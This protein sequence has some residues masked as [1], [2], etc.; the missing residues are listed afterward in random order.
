MY[1]WLWFWAPQVHFPWSGN[2]AQQI[3]PITHLFFQGIKPGAGNPQI[4]E[5]A[6][7]VAT[8]GKQLGLITDI[9]IELAEQT[10][11]KSPE[12]AMSLEKLKIV[13]NEIEA[14]KNAE[15]DGLATDIEAQVT[16]LQRKGGS[17]YVQL[18]ERLLPLLNARG[19]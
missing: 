11:N 12:T 13:R 1:P 18:T 15:Y 17:R 6:F 16:E 3:E 10:S 5:K 8:Y 2:V 19:A 4:E 14:I 7:S 9:L